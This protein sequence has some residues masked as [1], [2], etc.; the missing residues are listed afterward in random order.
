[1]RVEKATEIG[2]FIG[3]LAP[4]RCFDGHVKEPY[5][6]SIA[7]GARPYVQLLL[8]S[9][10][11]SMCCHIY[12]DLSLHVT[13]SNRSHSLTKEKNDNTQTR[14]TAGLCLA[15]SFAWL[16]GNSFEILVFD[17]CIFQEVLFVCKLYFKIEYYSQK[18]SFQM[19]NL[20][21]WIMIIFPESFR[22]FY[23]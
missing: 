13:F 15:K 20:S 9:A 3:I 19:V 16:I 23:L 7:F 14:A 6:M 12:N 1:M 21:F 18:A 4:C 22:M 5:E 11:T 10:C 2:R 8:Q 17:V